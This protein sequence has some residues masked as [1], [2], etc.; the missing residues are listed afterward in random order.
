MLRCSGSNHG[1]QAIHGDGVRNMDSIEELMIER[2]L[3]RYAE[4][5]AMAEEEVRNL[6]LVCDA[7]EAE[8][9]RAETELAAMKQP[10]VWRPNVETWHYDTGCHSS[11]DARFDYCPNCGHPVSVVRVAE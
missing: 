10:C 8:W 7:A 3:A 4:R 2:R 5:A 1:N 6:R 11:F 9:N